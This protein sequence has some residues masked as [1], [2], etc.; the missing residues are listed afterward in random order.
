MAIYAT[1]YNVTIKGDHAALYLLTWKD[2][3]DTL[4]EKITLYIRGG[5]LKGKKPKCLT[6]ISYF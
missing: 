3:H 5:K 4:S 6:V 1:E 2:V